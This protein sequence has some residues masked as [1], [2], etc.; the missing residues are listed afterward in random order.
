MYIQEKSKN[1]NN[2]KVLSIVGARPQFIKLAPLSI[3]LRKNGIKEIILH[4]GQHYDENMSEFFFKELEIPEPDYNLGIGSGFHGE[5][6]GRMLIGI[7]EVLIKEKP[8]VVIVYGDTNSTLAGALATSKLHI[9]LA[10][11]EAGLRSFNKNMPEE[12]NRIV[13]DHLSDILFAPTE[14]AVENLKREGIE[15]GVYLV[16][17][18]MFD[19]L[20][21][22]SKLAEEKSKILENLSLKSQDYYLV[23]IHRAENTD[24]P[25]KLKNIFSALQELDKEVIFPIHPRTKNRVKEFGLEDYLK[26]KVRIIDAVG[27]LDMIKLE[28]NAYAILTD[29]GGVQKEAFWLKVPCI[30]LREETEWVETVKFGWNRLVGTDKERILEAIRNIKGGEDVNFEEKYSAP[31]M[32][33]ILIKELEKRGGKL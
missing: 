3:E 14:T 8:D 27:Y 25:K 2:L 26:G 19:A 6:T 4:T 23:T 17:D 16:G 15:K 9:P 11:V 32:R 1:N 30:T 20:I 12:I 18:I 28:K 31:K 29:S 7:E 22:F 33:E 5:Q 13:V 24:N 21:H 10:H